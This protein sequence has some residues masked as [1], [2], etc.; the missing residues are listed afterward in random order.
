MTERAESRYG[1]AD[2][3][4]FACGD[5]NPIGMGLR[6]EL[7]ERR[8]SATWVPGADY[9]GWSDRVHGGL[10]ATVLDEVMAW[11]PSSD[12][13]WAVTASFAVR[14]HHPVRPGEELRAEGW[15]ESRRRRI[16]QVRGEVRSGDR[17]VAEAT[18]T[19]LGASPTQKAELKARY[20]WRPMGPPA[21][22]E[23]A[24]QQ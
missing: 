20:G 22:T 8:A 4:C 17:L 1:F 11:A 24:V 2:H 10:V 15:V 16:Y 13:A 7:G 6:I 12:D 3:H 23:G 14:F 21:V 9:V 19:Y 18:G 5:T